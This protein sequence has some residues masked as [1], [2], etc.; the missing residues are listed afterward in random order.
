M[1]AGLLRAGGAGGGARLPSARL[2]GGG[3]R[4]FVAKPVV[5]VLYGKEGAGGFSSGACGSA[6]HLGAG[7]GP[8]NPPGGGGRGL[9]GEVGVPELLPTTPVCFG[10]GPKLSGS[11]KA[12]SGAL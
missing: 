3:G 5:S 8:P 9:V 11:F 1:V 10:G 2:T 4:L 7:T 12:L 6:F